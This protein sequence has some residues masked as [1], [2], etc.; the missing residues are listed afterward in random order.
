MTLRFL[1]RL[2]DYCRR[3]EQAAPTEDEQAELRMAEVRA[4]IELLKLRADVQSRTVR[5][6][7]S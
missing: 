5:K 1:K 3:T 4:R 7:H 2:I 6:E